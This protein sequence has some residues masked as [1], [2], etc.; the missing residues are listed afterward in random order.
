MFYA[1]TPEGM[2]RV[3]DVRVDNGEMVIEDHAAHQ[4]VRLKASLGL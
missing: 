3:D 1:R 4:T 2:Q